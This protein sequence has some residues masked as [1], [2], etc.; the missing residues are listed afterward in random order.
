[1]VSLIDSLVLLANL[2]LDLG[3]SDSTLEKTARQT[4]IKALSE[5]HQLEPRLRPGS[6]EDKERAAEIQK[7]ETRLKKHVR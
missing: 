2:N 3:A 1:M 7:L 4:A 6:A 5:L